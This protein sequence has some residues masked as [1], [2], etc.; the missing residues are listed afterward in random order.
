MPQRSKVYAR[1]G[2]DD[3]I[4][5][6]LVLVEVAAG[7]EPGGACNNGARVDA[8]IPSSKRC[9]GSGMSRKLSVAMR[10]VP[11]S[12][13]ASGI[14]AS[15]GGS[16][17]RR[18]AL[19]IRKLPTAVWIVLRNSPA[20]QPR[21]WD[22]VIL[23]PWAVVARMTWNERGHACIHRPLQRSNRQPFGSAQP[24]PA[25]DRPRCRFSVG[26]A[27]DHAEESP[28]PSAVRSMYC[29]AAFPV[30]VLD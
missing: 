17:K 20:V 22:A 18:L 8:R 16:E 12:A 9:I 10:M 21:G 4:R 29:N 28:V 13:V 15:S 27:C 19:A 5:L 14:P 26:S 3:C 7:S 6:R 11:S 30:V 2:D 23:Y 24:T 25:G 1:S